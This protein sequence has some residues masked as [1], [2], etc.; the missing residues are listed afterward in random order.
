MSAPWNEDGGF[1][2]ERREAGYT[3]EQIGNEL[4]CPAHVARDLGERYHAELSARISRDQL[5]L[6]DLAPDS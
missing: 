5:P 6:F 1:A 3:W 4:G 2:W